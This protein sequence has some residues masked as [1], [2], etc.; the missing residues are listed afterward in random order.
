LSAQLT[1]KKIQKIFSFLPTRNCTGSRP[2][3]AGS[4]PPPLPKLGRRRCLKMAAA[5]ARRRPPSLPEVGRCRLPKSA[6]SAADRIRPPPWI[7]VAALAG[8]RPPPPLLDAGAG[9]THGIP[10]LR[11]QGSWRRSDGD[12]STAAVGNRS[13]RRR[14]RFGRFTASGEASFNPEDVDG[15]VD[16]WRRSEK[17]GE[18]RYSGPERRRRRRLRFLTG[19][20]QVVDRNSPAWGRGVAVVGQRGSSPAGEG[21]EP[22]R[23]TAAV[24]AV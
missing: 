3:C 5:A 8:N 7:S 6:A 10:L 16:L 18:A 14:P 17:L 15:E 1:L 12:E 24:G 11:S 13:W 20:K 9:A 23:S 19:K 4:R 2:R 21:R 22:R